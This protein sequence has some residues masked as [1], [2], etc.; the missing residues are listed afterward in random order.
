[1]STQ[2]LVSEP[3]SLLTLNVY[4]LVYTKKELVREEYSTF[5]FFFFHVFLRLK[6][7]HIDFCLSY[8]IYS[9]K[10]KDYVLTLF[11]LSH[12]DL[13]GFLFRCMIDMYRM[14]HSDFDR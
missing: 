10:D 11:V 8:I 7:F 9:S 3:F 2:W 1:M 6:G 14:I 13:H 12:A 5:G 4:F